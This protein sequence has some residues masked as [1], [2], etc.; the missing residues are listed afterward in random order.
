MLV[1]F[2]VLAGAARGLFTLVC[3]TLVSD[4]WGS[5]RYAAISCVFNAP[6]LAASALAL[7][8]GAVIADATGSLTGLFRLRSRSRRVRGSWRAPAR[9]RREWPRGPR[10]HRSSVDIGASWGRRRLSGEQ[11]LKEPDAKVYCV[12]LVEDLPGDVW[13]CRGPIPS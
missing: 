9:V 11:R 4:Y 12:V 2:A 10:R 6:I 3:A 1:L 5:E 8:L 7:W 13:V